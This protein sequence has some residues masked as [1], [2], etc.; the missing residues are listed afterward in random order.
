MSDRDRRSSSQVTDP[1]S[2]L[3]R[4]ALVLTGTGGDDFIRAQRLSS[5][6]L[7]FTLNEQLDTILPEF[8][9]QAP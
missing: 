3:R 2:P 8:V 9:T 5:G 4:T 6:L 1:Y 7:E